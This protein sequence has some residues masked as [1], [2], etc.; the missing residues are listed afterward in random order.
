MPMAHKAIVLMLH[1]IPMEL[2]EYRIAEYM[3]NCRC[4]DLCVGQYLVSRNIDF[5]NFGTFRYISLL[6][7]LRIFRLELDQVGRLRP[8]MAPTYISIHA[9]AVT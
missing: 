7:V 3:L 2:T 5:N 9:K 6:D 8:Y 4:S 1:R